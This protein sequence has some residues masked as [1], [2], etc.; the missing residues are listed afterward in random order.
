MKTDSRISGVLHILL[1]MADADGP[2]TS[3]RL[4]GMMQ[5]NPAVIR[6][7]LGGLR[8]RGIVSSEKGHGGGWRLARDPE[9]ITLYDI[10]DALDAPTILSIGNRHS[11]PSCQVEQAVNAVM[12]DAFREAEAVLLARFRE[13]TLGDLA[14]ERPIG[15]GSQHLP[16]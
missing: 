11:H 14:R 7:I 5:T 6:R 16:A 2:L 1:H 9:R 8:K 12:N 15:N 4:A 13:V 3:E 10:Y